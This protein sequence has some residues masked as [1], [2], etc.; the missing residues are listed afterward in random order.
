MSLIV[1]STSPLSNFLACVSDSQS[2]CEHCQS[3][4]AWGQLITW[5][6]GPA[7]APQLFLSF[8]CSQCPNLHVSDFSPSL[9]SSQRDI[10]RDYLLFWSQA[11]LISTWSQNRNYKSRKYLYFKPAATAARGFCIVP[12]QNHLLMS[13]TLHASPSPFKLNEASQLWPITNMMQ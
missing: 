13:K 2:Y 1:V 9:I 7:H 10:P 12:T 8:S 4:S 6:M 11:L 3:A 5:W